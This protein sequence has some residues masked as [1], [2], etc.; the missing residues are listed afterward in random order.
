MLVLCFGQRGVFLFREPRHVFVIGVLW[1]LSVVLTCFCEYDLL[2][3][4]CLLFGYKGMYVLMRCAVLLLAE[5]EGESANGMG[6][7]GGDGQAGGGQRR[8]SRGGWG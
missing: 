3:S 1:V 7:K 8:T 2:I 5:V 6:G 4:K